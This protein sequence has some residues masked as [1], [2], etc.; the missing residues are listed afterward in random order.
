MS[1]LHIDEISLVSKIVNII[2]H[3]DYGQFFLSTDI[4][5]TMTHPC[6]VYSLH[7]L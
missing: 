7:G 1:G 6:R 2:D 5:K 4:S 3:A